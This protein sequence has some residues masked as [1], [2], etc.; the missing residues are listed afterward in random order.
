MTYRHMDPRSYTI[1]VVFAIAALTICAAVA[2]GQAKAPADAIRSSAAYVEVLV[3]RTEVQAELEVLLAEYTDDFPKVAESRYAVELLD[4]ERTRLLGLKPADAGKLT[5]ALGR[6][7]VRKV[8]L[9]VELWILRKTLQDAHP[10]V[11]RAKRK[12]DIYESA[13][14]EILG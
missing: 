3:K 14:R 7:I 8:E 10:D 2:E 13:V 12:V 6:L 4:R 11:K 9:E 1:R 5:A